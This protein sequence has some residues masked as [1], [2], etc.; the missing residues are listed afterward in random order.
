MF[1]QKG[2]SFA[3]RIQKM[4]E[5]I[6]THDDYVDTMNRIEKHLQKVTQLGGFATLSEAEAEELATLS[7]VAEQ[8]E[9]AIPVFPIRPPQTLPEMLRLKMM[10]LNVKQ[11]VMAKMLHVSESKLSDV[12]ASKRRVDIDLAKK[13]YEILKI[14]AEFILQAA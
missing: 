6:T 12:L 14:E 3:D 13:L 10:Q 9:N 11:K 2:I 4:I 7:V 1:F 5:K 8:Y